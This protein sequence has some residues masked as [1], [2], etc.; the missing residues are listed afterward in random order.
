MKELRVWFFASNFTHM[1]M[2]QSVIRALRNRS[3]ALKIDV[4]SLALYYGQSTTAMYSN[5]YAEKIVVLKRQWSTD[6]Y[7]NAGLVNKAIMFFAAFFAVKALFSKRQVNLV[8]LGNDIG[9]VE[10]IIIKRA[11]VLG[12]PTLLV[13]DGILRRKNRL[14][15]RIERAI[16]SAW[17]S[18]LGISGNRIYGLGRTTAVA[19]M[20]TYTYELLKELGRDPESIFITGQPRFDRY[21]Q[22]LAD[23]ILNSQL[24]E[25]RHKL[26]IPD[27]SKVVVFFSQ[28]L[29]SYKLME[30]EHWDHIVGSVLLAVQGLIPNDCILVKLHPAEHLND[31]KTRY[32]VSLNELG[33]Y[34]IVND[35]FG[36]IDV[37]QVADVVIVYSS[38]VAL[39]AI[40]FDKP[41]IFFNPYDFRD[42]YRLVDLGVAVHAS[43]VDDLKR[44]LK[45][46]SSDTSSREKMKLARAKAIAYHV[47]ALDGSASRRTA[48]VALRLLDSLEKRLS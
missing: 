8:V 38:T 40:L 6:I 24:I 39:E 5:L 15:S 14:P 9:L 23:G 11:T 4:I 35:S 1:S 22:I 10:R 16:K 12:I 33:Q 36:L 2:W 29:I 26:D 3:S 44:Q 41:V 17:F 45:L 31:F 42:D 34:G 47:G 28:P 46:L 43:T 48:E 7:W 30:E 37:L 13:Q 25:L 18:A 21:A 19:V 32:V 20:G 27:G